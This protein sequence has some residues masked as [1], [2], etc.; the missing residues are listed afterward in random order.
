MNWR[1]HYVRKMGLQAARRDQDVA[2]AFLRLKAWFTHSR[3][4]KKTKQAA[5]ARTSRPCALF[6]SVPLALTRSL[7]ARSHHRKVDSATFP[8]MR[9]VSDTSTTQCERDERSFRLC[10]FAVRE[11]S[12]SRTRRTTS[13]ADRSSLALPPRSPKPP[14]ASPPPSTSTAS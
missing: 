14:S 4:A 9:L 11:T 5:R 8:P 1:D 10:D 3:L 12:M 6:R 7:P 2:D 13:A